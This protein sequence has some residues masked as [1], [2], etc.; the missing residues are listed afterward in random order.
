M[1]ILVAGGAGYI[2][3]HTVRALRA[4][5]HTTLVFDNFST[6]HRDL[7]LGDSFEGDLADPAAVRRALAQVRADAVMHF[8]ACCYVGESV[9]DPAKYYRNNVANT[10]TLLEAMREAG[11]SRFVFSSSA[12]TYGDPVRTPMDETHPQAPVNPYGWTKRMVEQA[13]RDFQAAY[14]LRSVALRYFNAAGASADARLGERHRPETH[15]VPL[16]VTAALGTAPPLKV[17]GD[18]YPTPDG[19][20][21]RD[22]IHV[23]DLADAH[24]RA[25][26]ALDGTTDWLA[27]NLGIGR[28]FTVR[29]VIAAVE[30]VGKRP[31]PRTIA[32]R[33]AGDPP[34]LVA[35]ATKARTALGWTPR[36]TE[37]DGIVE[38]AWR[39]H[40]KDGG[41]K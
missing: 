20:C 25:L 27:F 16:A 35:D 34:A 38:T 39:W 1:N 8:S 30:R 31:V 2:G 4:A 36:H 32:P 3:S 10:L 23:E 19:T 9:A 14:G 37:L 12:A 40:V 41:P 28:G 5:G 21:I 13:M 29:E 15:L 33:R 18:D 24:V 17:F 7:V 11:V 26:A 6:G 22:Y